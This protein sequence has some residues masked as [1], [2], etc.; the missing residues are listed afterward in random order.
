M[1]A[2]KCT[3]LES[4]M[5]YNKLKTVYIYHIVLFIMVLNNNK[6]LQ[7]SWYWLIPLNINYN[8]PD[9]I[10]L[11]STTEDQQSQ[12]FLTKQWV[13]LTNTLKLKIEDVHS[14][15]NANQQSPSSTITFTSFYC[16]QYYHI[17]NKSFMTFPS[18]VNWKCMK[19]NTKIINEFNIC[20]ADNAIINL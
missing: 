2:T 11:I 14:N 4:S 6:L 8:A 16:L 17:I 3:Q 19:L 12:N 13:I 7:G 15:I 10:K 20:L 9:D 18:R 1:L 5:Y